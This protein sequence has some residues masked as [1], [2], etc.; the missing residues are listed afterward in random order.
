MK[1]PY[2]LNQKSSV[3]VSIDGKPHTYLVNTPEFDTIVSFIRQNDDEGLVN[4]VNSF[5]KKVESKYGDSFRVENN[6]VFVKN[7]D[8]S[9]DSLPR[10]LGERVREFADEDLPVGPLLKF[11]KRLNQNPSYD[12]VHRLF[13]CLDKNNHPLLPDG[14][15]LAWKRIRSDRKDFYSGKFD[16]SD[17]SKPSV[18][19]NQ[20]DDDHKT[21]CSYGLH[22]SSY[23]YAKNHYHYGEGLM[24]EVAIDPK[25]VVSV[26]TD[27]NDQKMRV[28]TYEVFGEVTEEDKRPLA[29]YD[30]DDEEEICEDCG[31][32]LDSCMC[33]VCDMC[34][35]DLSDCSCEDTE[36]WDD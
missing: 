15:F 25:D 18:P 36:D 12:S 23:D 14:R 11:W 20:V 13:E 17:G 29:H 16:N 24:V 7:S 30:A 19:R 32:D 21:A 26:P 4:F 8:G 35:N 3:T 10:V 2:N 6:V 28:T 22:I 1:T 9:E 31:E 5:K 34:G 27:Y 33:D